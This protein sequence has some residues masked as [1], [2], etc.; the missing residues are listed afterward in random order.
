MLNEIIS[1]IVSTSALDI[2]YIRVWRMRFRLSSSLIRR[3]IGRRLPQQTNCHAAKRLGRSD[4]DYKNHGYFGQK[5]YHPENLFT[6]LVLASRLLHLF[7]I[8]QLNLYD[9][10]KWSQHVNEVRHILTLSQYGS[11][12]PCFHSSV[13]VWCEKKVYGDQFV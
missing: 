6:H 3:R 10:T 7:S 4:A 13:M 2:W 11:V 9:V 1:K 12:E 8:K 5:V